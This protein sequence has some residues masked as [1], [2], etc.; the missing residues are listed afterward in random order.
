ME[1]NFIVDWD[2]GLDCALLYWNTRLGR[3]HFVLLNTSTE[4]GRFQLAFHTCRPVSVPL[5]VWKP[6]DWRYGPMQ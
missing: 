1:N 3:S 6:I 2:P 4:K 5:W